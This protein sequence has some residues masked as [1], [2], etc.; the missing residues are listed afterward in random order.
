MPTTVCLHPEGE[1]QVSLFKV[2]V[3]FTESL[4]L[5]SANLPDLLF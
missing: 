5:P 1:A 4:N 2:T 3:G